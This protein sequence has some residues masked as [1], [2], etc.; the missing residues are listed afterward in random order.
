MI[1][2]C[3]S[4]GTK[5]SVA[6]AALQ[7]SG[8][9]VRCSNCGASWYQPPPE[10]PVQPRAPQPSLQPDPPPPIA[11][12]TPPPDDAR[13]GQVLGRFDDDTE[14]P[15][16]VTAE[17]TS[18]DLQTRGG[19]PAV[20]PAPGRIAAAWLL[21]ILLIGGTL[22][23]GYV[24]RQDVVRLWPPAY[25]LYHVMGVPVDVPLAVRFVP[26][27][28]FDIVDVVPQYRDDN[29]TVRLLVSGV[30][31]NTSAETLQVPPLIITVLDAAGDPLHSEIAPLPADQVAAGDGVPFAIP[32]QAPGLQADRL[33]LTLRA[34]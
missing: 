32:L 13:F 3:G 5:Y 23:A 12:P 1:I 26:A 16:P 25:Q 22:A 31:T 19:L 10:P 7:P 24:G 9:R 29:G 34:S 20:R 18:P 28:G 21:V 6:D 15:P 4:C 33:E 8:R 2:S 17:R 11:D 30:V 27:S 14:E